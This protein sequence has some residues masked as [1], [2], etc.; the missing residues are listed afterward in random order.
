MIC[1]IA[2]NRPLKK[3][4]RALNLAPR[5]HGKRRECVQGFETSN[6]DF[7]MGLPGTALGYCQ[8]LF[9]Y[10][11][12]PQLHTS[13][14]LKLL[15]EVE[16]P[17]SHSHELFWGHRQTESPGQ[18]I[19]RGMK[20]LV[21]SGR[22][23]ILIT[24]LDA[25]T[26]RAELESIIETSPAVPKN[27]TVLV[28][29]VLT[30]D[31]S[32][33][34]VAD[35]ISKLLRATRSTH[36]M[37][38]WWPL[39]QGS[40]TPQQWV[41]LQNSLG[42]DWQYVNV[43]VNPFVSENIFEMLREQ[44]TVGQITLGGPDSISDSGEIGIPREMKITGATEGATYSLIEFASKLWTLPMPPTLIVLGPTQAGWTD[45]INQQR[46][47]KL[48]PVL[49]RACEILWQSLT[50]ERRIEVWKMVA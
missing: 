2:D 19:E 27:E 39:L 24:G 29:T 23:P 30:D 6:G 17:W 32:I 49:R 36:T 38:K 34:E 47:A 50:P 21:G 13:K 11:G 44:I 20:P 8:A 41:L 22:V 43:A 46:I 14:V 15:T 33:R 5:C 35:I 4:E 40:L 3:L 10:A 37:P 12:S 7:V 48:L 31:S 25:K 18:F 42:E 28:R 1:S 16:A 9:G 45:L 26:H